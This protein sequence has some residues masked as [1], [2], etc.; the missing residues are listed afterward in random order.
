MALVVNLSVGRLISRNE[1]L[2][3]A[4]FNAVVKSIVINISGS[5]GNSDLA[6]G[7]VTADKIT[8]GPFFYTAPAVF[9]GTSTYTAAYAPVIT[10]Y[11]DGMVL[12]FKVDTTNPGPV[13]FNAGAGGKPL[14]KHGGQR[15]LDPGDALA[16]GILQVRFNTTLI[17][18]GCWEVMSLVGR[19]VETTPL[20]GAS[21]YGAGLSGLPPAPAAGQHTYY[22]RG[23]GQWVDVVTQITAAVAVSNTYLEIFKQQNFE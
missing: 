10:G 15:Q 21:P 13:N 11:V 3:T 17:A 12:A 1:K 7:A 9:D 16:N 4:K 6:A 5:V 14:V 18:G 2:T 23:D 19:P 8:N 22:L 20:V